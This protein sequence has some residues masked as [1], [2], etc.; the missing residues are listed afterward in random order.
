M[1]LS[2]ERLAYRAALSSR[3]W[4]EARRRRD[5]HPA[6]LGAA[7]DVE[8]DALACLASDP[9]DVGWMIVQWSVQAV[10]CDGQP[11]CRPWLLRARQ[12]DHLGLAA[13]QDEALIRFRQY[14]QDRRDYSAGA[15]VGTTLFLCKVVRTVPI[16]DLD[17]AKIM[18][19][20]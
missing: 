19:V 1:A 18:E 13:T 3:D 2:P 5:L 10:D 15:Q 8:D 11:G 14:V 4:A 20:Q 12:F 17:G 16:V 7:P 6:E 9:N